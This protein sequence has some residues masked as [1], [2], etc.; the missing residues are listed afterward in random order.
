MITADTAVLFDL[1]STLRNSRQRHHL[2][3]KRVDGALDPTADWHDYSA[4]GIHD[5]PMVGPITAL[6]LHYPHHQTH[7]ISGSNG[8]AM[9][10][11]VGWLDTYVGLQYLD[12]I[13]LRADG[14]RT[15]SGLYKVSYARKVEARGVKVVLV[16]ENWVPAVRELQEAGFPTVCVNPCYPCRTCG[17]DPL[18]DARA[19][20][21]DHVGGGL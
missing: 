3:P 10:Y 11:T 4:A 2:A 18:V 13:Q 1:D 6:K 15:P 21:R 12:H 7:I 19:G 17:T 8:S 14:D 5:E 20:Q 9:N 16:Y